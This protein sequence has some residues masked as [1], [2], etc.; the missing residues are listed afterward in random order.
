M[1]RSFKE[2][3]FIL[4]A[5]GIVF[6][7]VIG[8]SSPKTDTSES[9][10]PAAAA[11]T[12]DDTTTSQDTSTVY[13]AAPEPAA[14]KDTT[15]AQNPSADTEP[16]GKVES[17]LTGETLARYRALPEEYRVALEAYSAFG[18][19][20]DLI[21][22]VVAEKMAQWPDS[23]E[24]IQDLLD[25]ERYAQF[26]ELTAIHPNAKIGDKPRVH[27]HAFFFLGY[28][29]Y[30]LLNEDTVEG[31]K[32]AFAN[33]LDAMADRFE[34]GKKPNVAKP[35]LDR[36]IV[37]SALATLDTLGPRLRDAIAVP[38]PGWEIEIDALA[39][40]IV[41]TEVMLLKAEPGL[42]VPTLMESLPAEDQEVFKGLSADMREAAEGRYARHVVFRM[43]GLATSADHPTTSL[44]DEDVLSEVAQHEFEFAQMLAR[45]QEKKDG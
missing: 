33:L 9:A 19:S 36:L 11:A 43:I 32:Q 22:T 41:T 23:P 15:T 30:V 3:V 7:V 27:R 5:L 38:R 45:Q 21:P 37:P 31:R 25:A 1:R 13:S 16:A 34:L 29:P 14:A 20:D 18:V 42:E 44:P 8:C 17:L 26:Q 12:A 4:V 28:Y 35:R 6:G 10:E 24:P 2:V 39:A 40:D